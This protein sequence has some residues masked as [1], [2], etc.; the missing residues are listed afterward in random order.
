MDEFCLKRYLRSVIHM[1][2][3]LPSLYLSQI[4]FNPV[5]LVIVP[6][7][8]QVSNFDCVFY[9][10]YPTPFSTSQIFV[11]L[12][13]WLLVAISSS[14]EFFA[15]NQPK[16]GNQKTPR[17]HRAPAPFVSCLF[18]LNWLRCFFWPF[19]CFFPFLLTVN[20]V[21]LWQM[22]LSVHPTRAPINIQ[23]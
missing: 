2:Y 12:I 8:P 18:F 4:L 17:N 16:F 7:Q 9:F 19:L 20:G 1:K 22:L 15:L 21:Q 11:R 6:D 13:G 14:R 23:I 3:M 10:N 5:Q